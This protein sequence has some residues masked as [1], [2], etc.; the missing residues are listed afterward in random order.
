MKDK[1]SIM[2]SQQHVR[3]TTR[4]QQLFAALFETTYTAILLVDRRGTIETHNA[5]AEKMFKRLAGARGHVKIDDLLP[6]AFFRALNQGQDSDVCVDP[7]FQD[8]ETHE[9]TIALG[10]GEKEIPVELRVRRYDSDGTFKHVVR[11]RDIT[12]RKRLEREQIIRQAHMEVLLATTKSA[13]MIVDKHGMLQTFNEHA[14]TVLDRAIPEL[15]TTPIERMLP[16]IFSRRKDSHGGELLSVVPTYLDGEL[17]EVMLSPNNTKSFFA[18]VMVRPTIVAGEPIYIVRVRDITKRK[19]EQAESARRQ[20][21]VEILMDATNAALFIVN[22][23]GAIEECSANAMKVFACDPIAVKRYRMDQWV[24]TVFLAQG[25]ADGTIALTLRDPFTDHQMHDTNALRS[26]GQEFP[27]TI[28]VREEEL[29]GNQRFVVRV[30]D[31]TERKKLENDLRSREKRLETILN[32]A[33]EGIIVFDDRGIIESFN[34]AAEKLFGYTETEIRGQPIVTL[35]PPETRERREQYLDHFIRTEIQRLI[36]HEGEVVGRHQDGTKFPMA[37]KISE[38]EIDGRK[39]Y[40]GLVADISER[41]ALVEHLKNLAEHDGLTSLYN[42]GFFQA[43][44]ERV[45]ERTRRAGAA[46]CALLYI[47]LDNFKY[48]NDTLG[49]AAGDRVLIEVASIFIK[50]LRKSDLIARLGGDE[51]AV[52]LYNTSAEKVRQTAESFREQMANYIFS[53]GKERIDVGCSIG[54]SMITPETKSAVES[55]SQA[56]IACHLAKR[57]GRNRV[58]VFKPSDEADLTSM[59]LDMGWARRIREAI[60][61]NRFALACQPIVNTRTGLVD[62]YEVLIRMLDDKKELIMPGGFLPAAA[63]FGLIA[64]IDKWV[65]ANAIETLVKQRKHMP[66]LRYSINLSGQTFSDPTI[67]DLILAKLHQTGLEPA[68]L[69]FEI[70]ET[71]AIADMALAGSF[72]KRLQDIGCQTALDDFGSGFSSFAYLKDLPVDFVKIDGHFVKNL[73]KNPVDQAMVRAM[74]DIAHALGKQTVAEFV[75]DEA[76]MKLLREFGV[77]YAQGYHLGRPEV[78]LPCKA[79]SDHAVNAGLCRDKSVGRC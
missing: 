39:L 65:V 22:P 50:R 24:P 49:H 41:K 42:R 7:V 27:A 56:D 62:S 75:E 33:A 11:I 16:E 2:K 17:H 23:S 59:S 21:R 66:A 14:P 78:E 25:G 13:Y 48:V 58:H 46:H 31:V 77:D 19:R 47:D 64:D 32:N 9:R 79:I 54:V 51:F 38:M 8:G 72:L 63:R 52:L 53:Q 43:E 15:R 57:A 12:E 26:D 30:R 61:H 68:A 60:K 29:D 71:E 6:E 37:L 74:N 1:R 36:G 4:D 18:T 69:T 5:L 76:S 34:A 35:I 28:M 73:A 3:S 40:T 45:V 10:S 20:R 44:L 55:L 70:T 67:A